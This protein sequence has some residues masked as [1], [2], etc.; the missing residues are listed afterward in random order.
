VQF[1][2]GEQ[3]H[4]DLQT[5]QAL[6]RREIP[7][8]DV[9]AVFEKALRFLREKVEKDKLGR[10]SRR[11]SRPVIRPGADN[12]GRGATPEQPAPPLPSSREQAA[13]SRYIPKNVKRAVWYRDAGQ[14]AFLSEAG[15]RC[16]ERSFLELHHI[17]PFALDGPA[18]VGNI[19]LR[20]R[21]HNQYEAELAFG[22]RVG[23][24]KTGS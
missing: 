3:A 11:R 5:V 19:S 23:S 8:G 14:C 9:A 22:R 15:L 18:T 2:I 21:R 13:P 24:I 17:H 20:C 16:T 7:S 4:D 1:T 12:R 6:L 10:A